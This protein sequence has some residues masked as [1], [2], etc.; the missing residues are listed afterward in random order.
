MTCAAEIRRR[1]VT[2]HE[3]L[4]YLASRGFTYTADGWENGRWAAFLQRIE[5]GFGVTVWLRLQLAA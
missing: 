4:R 5:G 2:R 1:Y 3:A